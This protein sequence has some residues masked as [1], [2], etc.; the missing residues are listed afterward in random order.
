MVVGR[1]CRELRRSDPC[2]TAPPLTA[3]A[4]IARA[5]ATLSSIAPLSKWPNIIKGNPINLDQ[6]FSSLHHLHPPKESVGRM[7]STEITFTKQDPAK[8]IQTAGEWTSAWNLASCAYSF[9][10]PHCVNKLREYGDFIDGLF[11]SQLPS[12]TSK[13]ILVDKA[14]RNLVSSR[15]RISLTRPSPTQPNSLASSTPSYHQTVLKQE[16]ALKA[17]SR[18]PRH[19]PAE[20][21]CATG[22]T[23]EEDVTYRRESVV[24]PTSASRAVEP[25]MDKTL[26]RIEQE[27][28][29]EWVPKWRHWSMYGAH[30]PLHA[31]EWT[32]IAKPLPSPP[33]SVLSD[34]TVSSTIQNNP[35][36]FSIV[37]P[38]NVNQLE[39]LLATHPNQPFTSS[40]IRSFCEGFWPFADI[41]DSYPSTHD[42]SNPPPADLNKAQ[43]L[44]DQRDVELSVGC[45]SEGFHGLLP[46]MLRVRFKDSSFV[47]RFCNTHQC[48]FWCCLVAPH[49]IAS[50]IPFRLGHPV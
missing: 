41:P 7:G 14:I 34:K 3:S 26:A 8:H 44:C 25:G 9:V 24:S 48:K 18:E 22:S 31:Y 45:Y 19:V 10:F 27:L 2:S 12:S 38:V 28:K 6:F 46:G 23:D 37:T 33:S 42:A 47:L 1:A 20:F 16:E 11:A 36:L 17:Q 32:T 21:R 30:L 15:Q 29:R 43:F 35:D 50:M 49:V 13:I 4:P 5:F 39:Q 40:V